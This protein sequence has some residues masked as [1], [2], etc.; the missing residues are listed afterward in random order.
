MPP[1]H[2]AALDRDLARHQATGE[3][4]VVGVWREAEGRRKDGTTFPLELAI[5]EWRD[6]AGKRFFTAILRDITARKEAQARQSLLIREVDH[7]AKNALAVVQSLVRLTPAEDPKAYAQAVESRVTAL[8]RTHSLLAQRGWRATDL[9]VLI[10]AEVGPYAERVALEGPSVPI[11]VVAAQPLAMVVHELATNAAKHGAL[12]VPGGRVGVGWSVRDGSLH[13]HWEEEGG[14]LI[15]H[16]PTRLG[17][18][19][20]LIVASIRHQLGG[21]VARRWLH[22]GLVC[23]I[24]VPLARVVGKEAEAA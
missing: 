21:S 19:T 14:P 24:A 4:G 18:G 5:A 1:P 7:R 15:E 9:R 12:S 20:R 16:A 22:Q 17:F 6:A 11:S 2:A 3:G 8:A 10:E 13:L 23:E